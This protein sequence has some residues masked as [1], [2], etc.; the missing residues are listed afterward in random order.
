M[1]D[2]DRLIL[3]PAMGAFAMP[4][5]VLPKNGSPYLARGDFRRPTADVEIE[6]GKLTTA[7][8][9]LGVRASEF[10]VLPV[11]NDSIYVRVRPNADAPAGFEIVMGVTQRYLITDVRPD[12]EGDIK[13][14]LRE[15]STP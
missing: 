14:V 5:A 1:I 7:S 3:G 6:E 11:Q 4:I 8:P 13:L 9:T 10:P 12:G 15:Q 2:F